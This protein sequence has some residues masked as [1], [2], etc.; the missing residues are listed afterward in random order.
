MKKKIRVR[1]LRG[2][3]GRDLNGKRVRGVVGDEFD[4]PPGVD[5][6]RAGL[7]EAVKKTVTKTA[8]KKIENAARVTG[9]NAD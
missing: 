9:S 1:V 3:V 8:K 5:W 4:L 2:F 7:V 6:L